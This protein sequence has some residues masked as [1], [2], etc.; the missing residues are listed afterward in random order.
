M[1]QVQV[2]ASEGI[3]YDALDGISSLIAAF[4]EDESL[5]AIRNQLLLQVGLQ[6]IPTDQ[7]TTRGVPDVQPAAEI[8][9]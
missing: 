6:G 7:Q 9:Q 2:F 3:W 5:R 4:P 8:T 1:Q